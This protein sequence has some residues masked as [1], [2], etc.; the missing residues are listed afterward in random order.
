MWRSAQSGKHR[1]ARTMGADLDS[2]IAK[3]RA[4]E[5]LPEND[6]KQLCQMVMCPCIACGSPRRRGACRA[7]AALGRAG[8]TCCSL[9]EGTPAALRSTKHAAGTR[10]R[11]LTLHARR[12]LRDCVPASGAECP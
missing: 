12:A 1:E 8:R 4:C 2:W 3:V 10:A 6:L 9:W 11:V 7:Q 5:Y